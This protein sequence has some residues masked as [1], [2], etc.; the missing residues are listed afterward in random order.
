M[1]AYSDLISIGQIYDDNLTN[2]TKLKRVQNVT[3]IL[4]SYGVNI[5]KQTLKLDKSD[6]SGNPFLKSLHRN[7][8]SQVITYLQIT[9][10]TFKR[11]DVFVFVV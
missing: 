6:A 4:L 7:N 10:Y 9:V 2:C 8:G 11:L 5:H 3:N 1:C